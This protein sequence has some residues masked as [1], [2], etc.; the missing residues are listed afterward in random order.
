MSHQDFNKSMSFRI[1]CLSVA[2]AL[3]SAGAPAAQTVHP[4][5]WPAAH[6]AP[7]VDV[8]TEVRIAAMV[9]RM[10]LEEKVGQTIQ[11][12]ISTVTPADLRKYPL[13]SVLA[14]GD[15][16]PYGD[17]RA[18]PAEWLKLAREFHAVALEARPGHEPIPVIFGIDAVHGHNNVVGA[19]LYPQNIGLG[20]THE[21]DLVRRIA[22]ATAEEVAATGIDY[23]FAPT[24]AVPQDVRWGR[25]Y[26]GFSADP[27]QVAKFAAAAVIGLQGPNGMEHRLARGH[28]ASSIKHFLGDG[29]TTF[30]EDQGN[31]EVSE[32]TLVRT[33]APGYAAGVE[34]GALT[35]MAS[36]SAWNGQKMHGSKALLTDVLKGRMGFQGFVI[37]DY[38][39]HA[40]LPGCSKEHCP[41]ALNAGIDMYMAPLGWR[42]LYVNLIADVKAGRISMARLDDAVTRILRVKFALG[43]FESERPMEGKFERIS[44]P[45]HRALAREAVRKSL[46]LLKNDGVL[47]IR[48]N[49]KVVIGG[50]HAGNL[51]VQFG[52]WTLTWQGDDTRTADFPQAEL[53]ATAIKS[54]IRAGGGR[55][56]E[57]SDDLIKDRPDL[58]VV[59]MGSRPYAEMF[60][61]I[62][63]PLYN[64]RTGLRALNYFKRLGIPTVTVFLAGRPLWVNP[65]INASNAFVAAWLPGSEGG[66]IADVLVGT[67]DGKPRYD[68][69]GRLSFPWPRSALLPP[70]APHGATEFPMGFGISYV[71]PVRTPLL[72][73]RIDGLVDPPTTLRVK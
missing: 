12:D 7:L 33:H 10:S 11:S 2:V 38:N 25:S 6:P 64:E 19:E 62:K 18:K 73:E 36:Y 58:A 27:Q 26:E 20:A 41:D 34:A 8:T 17:E 14:G 50:P 48:A 67:A 46:V 5:L 71:S 37:G 15:S 3:L 69:I 43:M 53:A 22:E 24:I 52:G 35:V 4:T 28:V 63:L 23:A 29:G 13:G 32:E 72:S 61:D 42:D 49:A 70:F 45:E 56:L 16:G 59:I 31:T 66:G 40:M 47:P 68:F 9:K 55:V 30:G 44:S 39:A 1:A 51:A 54:A 21:P 60:G 57:E 65:E